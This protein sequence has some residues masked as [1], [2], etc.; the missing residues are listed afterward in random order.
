MKKEKPAGK[1][2]LLGERSF[3]VDIAQK[4]FSSNYGEVDLTKIKEYG[5][6]VKTNTG[7]KF[8]VLRPTILDLLRKAKRMPQIVTPKDAGQI[9]ANTGVSNGWHCLDAGSGSGF[10]AI[11]LGNIVRPNGSVVTYE[12][13]KV[14]YEN[15]KKNI[16]FCNL[17]EIVKIKNKP[18]EKFTERNLD[19][20]T[21]DMINAE[22]MVKKC[23]SAMK[24]GGWLVIYSP[25]IEQ[26]K[27]VLKET[28]KHNFVQVKTIQTQQTEWQVSDYTHP[29][30][31]QLVHTGFITFARKAA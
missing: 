10:L 7:H 26:Q 19:L 24:K 5:Q 31:S 13:K 27:R 2:L 3:I 28:K 6:V 4:K 9:I 18:A 22:K 29:K 12:K 30:P 20:I 14:F 8:V 11:L 1:I 21:L 17:A 16:E 23:F 25:H 15:A